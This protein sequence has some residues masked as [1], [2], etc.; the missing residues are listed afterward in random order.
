MSSISPPT[1]KQ[2]KWENKHPIE[3][4]S[5]WAPSDADFQLQLSG[6]HVHILRKLYLYSAKMS[7]L[8][9]SFRMCMWANMTA[10]AVSGTCCSVSHSNT[11]L[12]LYITQCNLAPKKINT[13]NWPAPDVA[14]SLQFACYYLLESSQCFHAQ[15]LGY[16]SSGLWLVC[17]PLLLRAALPRESFFRKVMDLP[18]HTTN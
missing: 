3:T 5:T 10:L 4:S 13:T 8:W 6:L 16:H 7:R 12:K 18:A 1:P 15:M 2:H 14:Q 17:A 9:F 11:C